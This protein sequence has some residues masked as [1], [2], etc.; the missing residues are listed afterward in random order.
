MPLRGFNAA[1]D[2]TV[3]VNDG[4]STSTFAQF[5]DA[6]FDVSV[7]DSSLTFRSRCHWDSYLSDGQEYY[8]FYPFR[9]GITN[10]QPD[11]VRC[12]GE[13]DYVDGDMTI[14]VKANDGTVIYDQQ[15]TA[16][17]D[18]GWLDTS[19]GGF[20]GNWFR[21]ETGNSEES[22]AGYTILEYTVSSGYSIDDI[23]KGGGVTNRGG[24]APSSVGLGRA[25]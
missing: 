23:S 14:R 9:G 15:K 25:A 13:F 7:S 20:G 5:G 3:D 18:T 12:Y 19:G 4:E 8:Q 17:H 2:S 11:R 10:R 16:P 1:M 21:Q 6:E 24:S 22:C